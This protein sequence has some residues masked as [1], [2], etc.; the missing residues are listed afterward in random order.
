MDLILKRDPA[1][2]DKDFYLVF[3][4]EKLVGRIFNRL[5]GTG[6]REQGTWF[7]GL[8][9]LVFLGRGCKPPHYGDAETREEAMQKFKATWASGWPG[10]AA[11]R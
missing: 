5:A 4:G 7:W 11:G 6:V 3:D 8:D 2:S 1:A 9:Y 10:T